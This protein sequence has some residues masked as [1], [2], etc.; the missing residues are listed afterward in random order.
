MSRESNKPV[1]MTLRLYRAL[2]NAFPHEFKNVYGDELMQVTEDAI[3]P[4][5]RQHGV[6]GLIRLLLDIAI[7]VP[8]EH[9][10]ELW[11]DVRYGLRMLRGSKG[12]TAVALIS[13][14]LGIAVATSAFSEMNAVILRRLPGVPQPD[15]L[16]ALQPA[17]S[18]PAYQRFRQRSDLFSAAFA[19]VAPV[20]F[21]VWLDGHTER[22]WGHLVTSSCF[23]TLGARPVLGRASK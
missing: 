13:L 23:S 12:F 21:G 15:Q 9:G 14:G 3:E 22:I 10:A 1:A 4:I 19:Y 17:A 18:Y 7:R 2:A 8:A 16:V 11:Q 6:L 5:W 20:P